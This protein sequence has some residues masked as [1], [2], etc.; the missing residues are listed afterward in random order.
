MLQAQCA[1]YGQHQNAAMLLARYAAHTLNIF[2]MRL[3]NVYTTLAVLL[4]FIIALILAANTVIAVTRIVTQL[5]NDQSM[6]GGDV[7]HAQSGHLDEV[8]EWH[9]LNEL[10][11]DEEPVSWTGSDSNHGEEHGNARRRRPVT[12]F[13]DVY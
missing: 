10:E 1:A 6:C 5:Q 12:A 11:L 4:V 9:V 7:R 2:T 8:M 13:H 3:S